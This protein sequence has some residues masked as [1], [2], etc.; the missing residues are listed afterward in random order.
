MVTYLNLG[1]YGRLGNQMFE[2]AGTIGLA[3]KSG[4][5]YGFPLWM[6]YDHVTRFHS[7]EDICIQDYFINPLPRPHVGEY[8]SFNI[9]WGYWD[10]TVP[11]NATI[12][13]HMQSEKYFKHCAQ[14]IRHYFEMKPLSNL[15]IPDNAIAIH[16]RLG[17]YDNNY[18]TRLNMNYYGK[19]LRDFPMNYKWYVF[20]DDPMHARKMF[21]FNAEYIEGNH[22]MTDFYLMT[23][24]KNFI[25]GNSTFSWWPA[26]LSTQPGKVVYAPQNWFGPMAK[27]SPKD[28]YCDGWKV[29]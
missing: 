13:G 1:K 8:K 23:R 6:N 2:I 15:A 27:I 9:R 26:W 22:Y 12:E 10:I 21:G 7:N 28:I 4:H 5:Q 20:S 17:D 11:D 18:H 24:F 14:V 25:I 3:I 16:V 19:A 29:I